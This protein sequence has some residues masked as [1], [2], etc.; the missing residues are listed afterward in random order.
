MA[1]KGLVD[2]LAKAEQLRKRA[3]EAAADA[4]ERE[5]EIRRQLSRE[6]RQKDSRAMVIVGRVFREWANE[7]SDEDER[8]KRHEGLARIMARAT[9]EELEFVATRFEIPELASTKKED[10]KDGGPESLDGE[11]SP[12]NDSGSGSGDRAVPS[13][14]RLKAREMVRAQE[15][16]EF[17][18][19]GLAKSGFSIPEV[20]LLALRKRK[21][22]WV[23][24]EDVLADDGWDIVHEEKG[25]R[26]SKRNS[27]KR[28]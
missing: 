22:G 24:E 10:L 6:E 14:G 9:P 1:G 8:K 12:E 25:I 11:G 5:K 19:I 18:W 23:F 21:K 17:M 20:W 15:L 27:G 4:R 26:I 2:R 7:E 13:P 3:E 28:Q 16:G